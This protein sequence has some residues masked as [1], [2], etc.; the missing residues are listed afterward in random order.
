MFCSAP[1]SAEALQYVQL[2]SECSSAAGVANGTAFATEYSMANSNGL[3]EV[4][5]WWAAAVG[6]ATNWL[7]GDDNAAERL[8]TIMDAFPKQLQNSDASLPKS[9]Y[10]A[11]KARKGLLSGKK[12][13]CNYNC[14]KQ[15]DRAGE[16]L[17]ENL[18]LSSEKQAQGLSEVSKI[19]IFRTRKS[20]YR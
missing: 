13:S 6:I 3:D 14:I 20:H 10:I 7:T 15:C 17:R 19:N 5:R 18:I 8:Y 12:S 2:L 9:L 4:S 1:H 11:Y 16:Q